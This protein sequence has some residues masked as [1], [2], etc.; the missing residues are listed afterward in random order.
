MNKKFALPAFCF[1]LILGTTLFSL[2]LDH[3]PAAA[4]FG[5][6]TLI[7][8]DAASGIIPPSGTMN[9]ADFPPGAAPP[10][11]ENRATLLD[12]TA[13]GNNTYAG[14]VSTGTTI[15]GFPILDRTAGFQVNFIVQVESE[16]HA[17]KNRA[18]LSVIILS[19]DAKGIELAFWENEIHAQNDDATGGLFKHGEATTF[20]TTIGL[21]NYQVSI[22]NDTYTLT[23]NSVVILKGPIRDYSNF[24]GFPD[25]YETPNF[26]FLGDDTT[27]AQAS[28]RL[29][30]VSVTGTE[31]TIPPDSSSNSPTPSVRI[32]PGSSPT[33]MMKDFESCSSIYHR[34]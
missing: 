17:N 21:I 28:M 16:S 3:T 10:K 8:Y 4:A 22:I 30:Y 31:S 5:G 29:A 11:F 33:P 34:P 12:T 1:V 18:G 6:K 7:L 25:P 15:P 9:F 13:T 14:W 19:D 26:L 2:N 27:S 24:S 20:T 23:A 32:T